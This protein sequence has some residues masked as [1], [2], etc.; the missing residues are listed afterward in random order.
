[1]NL[2][3]ANQKFGPALM[4]RLV[5][6]PKYCGKFESLRN[7][8]APIPFECSSRHMAHHGALMGEYCLQN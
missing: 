2:K 6:G 7:N 8:S 3:K 4:G 5:G 1:M